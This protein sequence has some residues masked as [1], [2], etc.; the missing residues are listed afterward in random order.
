MARL[1]PELEQAIAARVRYYRDLG[2]FDF[3]RRGDA[4]VDSEAAAQTPESL[5]LSVTQ[6]D[7]TMPKKQSS[8]PA[9]DLYPVQQSVTP[10]T[11]RD[12]ALC[13][14]QQDIGDCTRCPLAFAGRHTIVFG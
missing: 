2:V 12:A 7:E 10:P 13:L 8:V 3:Y 11:E 6:P 9:T 14:I 5:S 4:A 1:N